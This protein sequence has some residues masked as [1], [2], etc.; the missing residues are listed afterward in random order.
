MRSTKWTLSKVATRLTC[1]MDEPLE[2]NC[3][4]Y[5]SIKLW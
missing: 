4:A 5:V 3:A 1:L 2:A